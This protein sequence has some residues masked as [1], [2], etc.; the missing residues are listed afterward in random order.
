MDMVRGA[1]GLLVTQMQLRVAC[2]CLVSITDYT[3]NSHNKGPC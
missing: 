3:C 2:I 1:Y